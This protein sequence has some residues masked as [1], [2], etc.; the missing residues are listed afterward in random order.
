MIKLKL[1]IKENDTTKGKLAKFSQVGNPRKE[2]IFNIKTR[3]NDAIGYENVDKK[4]LK[5][6]LDFV[7]GVPKKNLVNSFLTGKMKRFEMK[8]LENYG[9]EEP[10]WIDENSF[11]YLSEFNGKEINQ[12]ISVYNKNINNNGKWKVS[13]PERLAMAKVFKIGMG[14][15]F[16][17]LSAL[18]R[19]DMNIFLK[20]TDIIKL[21]NI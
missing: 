11:K 16:N 19:G 3:G 20:N 8:S 21:S 9:W 6:F 4:T 12:I 15:F 14:E 17:D 13:T 18:F 7:K 1:L 5:Q 2:I 10:E